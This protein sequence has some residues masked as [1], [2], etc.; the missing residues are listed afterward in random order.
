MSSDGKAT[1][2][3]WTC[4]AYKER[5]PSFPYNELFV[6]IEGTLMVTVNGSESLGAK[7]VPDGSETVVPFLQ[8]AVGN[9]SNLRL[10]SSG[11]WDS[12]PRPRA[13]KARALTRLRY[14]PLSRGYPST[15]RG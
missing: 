6:V 8:Q 3:V 5:I 11:R 9:P 12:N 4:G 13:P 10:S 1:C 15:P 7:K 2:G 14:A